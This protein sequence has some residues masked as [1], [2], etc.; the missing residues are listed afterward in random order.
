[1]LGHARSENVWDIAAILFYR[2]SHHKLHFELLPWETW[3][4]RT[5]SHP[6]VKHRRSLQA[7][8]RSKRPQAT[9]A[10][11]K[12]TGVLLWSPAVHMWFPKIIHFNRI[13]HD[14][15]TSFGIPRLW[16]PPCLNVFEMVCLRWIRIATKLPATAWRAQP[17]QQ[18][19]AREK[20]CCHVHASRVK[21]LGNSTM[22]VCIYM[23]V[24]VYIYNHIYI[25]YM[26]IYL[27]VFTH[28]Y[29]ARPWNPETLNRLH[30]RPALQQ[31]WHKF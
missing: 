29:S 30:S 5:R 12:Q 26:R 16:K 23:C 10:L 14:K 18:Q 6:L 2:Y 1:M 28:R 13:V 22:Y 15:P 19:L 21:H 8:E 17:S 11:V 3:G 27:V 24:C 7:S 9:Q 4:F 20:D 31:S 25:Q